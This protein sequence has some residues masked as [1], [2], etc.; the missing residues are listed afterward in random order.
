MFCIINNNDNRP[1]SMLVLTSHNKEDNQ[2][3]V[4]LICMVQ[5]PQLEQ[6]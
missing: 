3:G 1:I 5:W 4:A 6:T 2:I